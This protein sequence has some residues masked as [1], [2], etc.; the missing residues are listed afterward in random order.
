MALRDETHIPKGGKIPLLGLRI[1]QLVLAI[2]ILGL[3][4]YGVYWLV[5][6]GD[7]L[8]LSA[9]VISIVICVY[10]ICASTLAPVMYN[11]WAILG[12]DI[13]AV[14]LWAVSFPILAAQIANSV[15][16]DT[17]YSYDPY[18]GDYYYKNKRGMGNQKRATTTWETYRNTMFATAALGGVEF[19]P[20]NSQYSASSS[21]QGRRSLCTRWCS[22]RRNDIETKPQRN[23]VTTAEQTQPEVYHPPVS[24]PQ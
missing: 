16:Y 9:A 11:Y 19:H 21:S 13:I 15:I 7:A 24:H 4:S 10:V 23:T 1:A 8:A 20:R 3:S 5:Y 17:G 18:Y 6:D 12:L 2:V 22:P 14:I